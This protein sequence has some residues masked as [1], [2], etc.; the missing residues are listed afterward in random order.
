[1]STDTTVPVSATGFNINAHDQ[2]N[3]KTFDEV[4][5]SFNPSVHSGIA[6]DLTG[7]KVTDKGTQQQVFL[8]GVDLDRCVSGFDADGSP[9][10]TAQK[11]E[12]RVRLKNRSQ[13]PGSC[14]LNCE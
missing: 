6:I 9:I 14:W 2:K 13:C 7:Q 5:S 3:W 1:M 10:L 4:L 8:I 11:R 12:Q